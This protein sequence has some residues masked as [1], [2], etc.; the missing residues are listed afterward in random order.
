MNRKSRIILA[1]VLV[2]I[3]SVSV[4]HIVRAYGRNFVFPAARRSVISGYTYA[5]PEQPS[6][7]AWDY[8]YTAHTKVAAAQ[9]GWVA[10][11]RWVWPDGHELCDNSIDSRGNF[12]ILNHTSDDRTEGTG[13]ETWYFHLS[14][15]G[16][17][18]AP[19]TYFDMGQYI[20]YSGDTGCGDAHLHFAAKD[21]G[22]PFDLYAGTTEWVGG[23]PIPMG[24]RDQNFAVQG[25]YP[26]SLTKIR[27]KWIELQ[28]S[29][30]SPTGNYGAGPVTSWS[31]PM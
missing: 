15:T 16:N 5:D 11:S 9:N 17:Q 21:N 29:P 28:G 10:R 24:Y 1:L 18:P 4:R 2:I 14:N 12:I 8:R 27:E 30:G 25:P 23:E 7:L 13:L 26:I 19:G 20:A 3:L 31:R 6:H 22:T